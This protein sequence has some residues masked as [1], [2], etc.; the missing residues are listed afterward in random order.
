MI[1]QS[2]PLTNRIP[3]YSLMKD[4]AAHPQKQDPSDRVPKSLQANYFPDSTVDV[5]FIHPTTYLTV[6]KNGGN[7]DIDDADL[8]DK[9]DQAPILYQASVFNESCR[10][11]APRYRQAHY[12]NY[13]TKDTLASVKA[14]DLAYQDV[15]AAFEYY[16]QHFNGGRPIIIA[17]HSQGTNHAARLLKELFEG[18]LLYNK[19]VCAYLVGMP[20]PDN[21]FRSIPA[22][23]DSSSTGC[24]VGWR[25]FRKGTEGPKY[26]REE[27]YNSIVTN[28]LLWDT[29][30]QAAPR[31]LNSGGILKNFNKMRPGVV[32]AQVHNNILWTS[33]PKFFGNFLLRRKN[34]HIGDINLFY[35]N[36]RQ[37][38]KRRIGLYWKR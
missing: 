36:I 3:D 2:V 35:N 32:N 23:T 37:D 21:Y 31:K 24:F 9:T 34:Y 8:N 1:P 6:K 16:F 29:S 27:K 33:K 17:A 5:F 7:A 20:T 11:F 4:W 19:L 14:F 10:V 26:I 28:P 18:K 12:H 25:S 38:V 15:K 30:Y 22:C 13:F